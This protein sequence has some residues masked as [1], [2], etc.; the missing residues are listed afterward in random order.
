M[1]SVDVIIPVYK[2]DEKLNK[3]LTALETQTV[4]PERIIIVHTGEVLS[5][6]PDYL[7]KNICFRKIEK[8]HFDHGGS[9][10]LGASLSTA[11]VMVF[12]TQDAVPANEYLLE[13]L[14]AALGM[15]ECFGM[16]AVY[17][18]QLPYEDCRA[19]ERYIREFNYPAKSEIR[20]KADI[21]ARGIKTFCLS[22]VCAAY[23]REVFDQ[24]GGF[25]EQ[26][27]F[28]E[29][30]LFGAKAIN[31][32]YGVVYAAEATVYHSHNLGLC[33]QFHR[34]F[35]NAV[36][37]ADHP[38]V[39]AEVSSEKEGMKLVR[40]CIS[41]MKADGKL[42]LVPYFVLNCACRYAGF[43]LGKRYRKL[44]MWLVRACS[45][46]KRYWD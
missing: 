23:R 7:A 19:V 16:A 40:Y 9:R 15:S 37:Q 41:R 32:G 27:I 22:N 28:N 46:N 13:K 10:N 30:M 44:P 33:D 29:D 8:G 43:F 39:F 17:A 6:E 12:M 4:K 38:K 26:T 20:T 25:V 21:P 31:A 24:L 1:V 42:Y 35:D 5:G 14:V 2:P 11:D 34:N 36:S 3:L 45:L 18:R